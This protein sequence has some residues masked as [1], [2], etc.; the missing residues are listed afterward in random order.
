MK[1]AEAARWDE[2]NI[3]FGKKDKLPMMTLNHLFFVLFNF[4][5]RPTLS[6][7]VAQRTFFVRRH[8]AFPGHN[9]LFS[10][11]FS[12]KNHKNIIPFD[13]SSVDGSF[14]RPKRQCFEVYI[15]YKQVNFRY[16]LPLRLGSR[17]WTLG[18]SDF[19]N[20]MGFSS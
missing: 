19:N 12:K 16:F 13:C 3:W 20:L 2:V 6:R 18:Y 10:F 7:S 14:F 15:L 4:C 8:P 17:Y 1:T 11:F 9:Q 5:I